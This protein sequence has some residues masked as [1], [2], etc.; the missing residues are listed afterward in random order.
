[1]VIHGG[2]NS[3]M[4]LTALLSMSPFDSTVIQCS[5]EFFWEY[6]HKNDTEWALSLAK[7]RM[8]S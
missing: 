6:P 1:M 7:L 4:D 2:I 3:K 5:A 8:S